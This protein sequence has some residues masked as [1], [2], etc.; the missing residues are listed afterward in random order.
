MEFATPTTLEALHQADDIVVSSSGGVD[1]LVTLLRTFEIC[2]DAGV[3]SKLSVVHADMGEQEHAGST[4]L[5]TAQC[6]A[7]GLPLTI[8]RRNVSAACAAGTC[9]HPGPPDRGSLIDQWEHKGMHSRIGSSNCQGTSD[10]KVGPIRRHYT[11]LVKAHKGSAPHKL[12]EVVGLAA[13][14]GRARRTR[15]QGGGKNNTAPKTTT[16]LGGRFECATD[17]KLTNGRRSTV[18]WWPIAD[19]ER[20]EIWAEVDRCAAEYGADIDREVYAVLPRYSC[21]VCVFASRHAL[22]VSAQRN[23][24]L[25]ARVVA[26][27]KSFA[28]PWNS[29]FTLADVAEDVASGRTVKSAKTWGDQA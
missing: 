9:S 24:E 23:P 14:E 15:L 3:L 20:D 29:K 28:R 4:A 26:I 17:S 21:Q 2:R 27:E 19:L 18:T 10:H 16:E 8:V 7:F 22:N 6:A 25:F 5:V 13:H 1:S 11:S 12:I